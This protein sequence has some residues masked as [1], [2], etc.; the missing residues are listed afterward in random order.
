MDANSLMQEQFE[1]VSKMKAVETLKRWQRTSAYT[2]E[3]LFKIHQMFKKTSKFN[4]VVLNKSCLV[5][6]HSF[7]RWKAGITKIRTKASRQKMIE[8]G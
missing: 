6:Q 7:F 4:I 3:D 8:L 2:D 1:M 5:I